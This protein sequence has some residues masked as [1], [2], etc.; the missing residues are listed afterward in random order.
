MDISLTSRRI[1]C[2]R[3]IPAANLPRAGKPLRNQ[4]R[5]DRNESCNRS[6][7]RMTNVM[8]EPLLRPMSNV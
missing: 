6:C 1:E 8:R 4:V 7:A 3:R 5:I 2:L